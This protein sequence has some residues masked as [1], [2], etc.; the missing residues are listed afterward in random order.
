MPALDTG[1]IGK[2]REA[3][4]EKGLRVALAES[5]TGGLLAHALTLMPGASGFFDSSV[6]C[7]SRQAKTRL[8]GLGETF[9]AEHGTVSEETARAMAVSAREKSE[10]EVGVGITG[11]LGPGTVEGKEAGLVFVAVSMG[12][13]VFSRRFLFAG[14]RDEIKHSAANAALLLLREAVSR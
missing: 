8:L 3:L 10:V 13:E 7:Y 9:L 2:V 4:R 14:E 1:I 12:S 6:V 11:A 5:C